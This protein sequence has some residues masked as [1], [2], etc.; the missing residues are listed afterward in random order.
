MDLAPS[1]YTKKRGVVMGENH[2]ETNTISTSDDK[3]DGFVTELIWILKG[4]LYPCWSGSF[5]Q[6]TAR[7][8]IIL[9]F[10]FF[11]LF[12]FLLTS[13]STIR[14]ALS[15]SEFES[16]IEV[17]F[18]R[19]EFPTITIR[20]GIALVDG[21]QPFVIVDEGRSFFAIDTSGKYQEIDLSRYSEGF[22]LT[23]TSLHVLDDREYQQVPLD[24]LNEVFGNPIVLD[25]SQVL[26]IWDTVA[27]FINWIVFLGLSLW[28]SLIRF[29]HIALT[30]LAIWGI[31]SI[32]RSG[33][34]FGPILIT[35]IYA[36]VP[37]IYGHFLL[38]QIG[39]AFLGLYSILLILIWA[40]AL[41]AVFA[42]AHVVDNSGKSNV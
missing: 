42:E 19:G 29:A 28:N 26:Q 40:I 14:I 18:D 33:T 25:E 13:I 12:A 8:R 7:R 6:A 17:A 4:F 22:L 35:G 16:E 41:R 32:K 23:R 20:D 36:N 30:G 10:V 9:A 27:L 37:A 38:A 5:Y 34:S 31:V 2:S 24:E 3:Q 15:L 39:F 21:P 11:L 1:H